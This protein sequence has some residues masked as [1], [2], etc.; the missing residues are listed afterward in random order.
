MENQLTGKL[1]AGWDKALPVFPADTKGAATRKSSGAVI[2]ALAGNLPALMGGS[3]DLAPSNNTLIKDSVDFQ[4]DTPEGRNMR[5]GVREHAMGAIINGMAYH[6][7]IIPYGATFM[8]FT[9][10][11]RPAMRLAALSHLPT[12]WVMTHDSIFLGEDGPTHQ[13]VEHLAAMRA[14][15]NLNVIRPADANE[16]TEAWKV[17]IESTSTPTMLALSRQNLPTLDRS[18]YAAADG[19]SK[20]AYVLKDFGSGTPDII[21][22][23]SGSEV[24]L[25]TTAGEA[26]AADG[27][28]VRLVSFPCWK[29]FSAQ[30][31]AYQESVLPKAVTK[32]L[33]V[34][35]GVSLG[36]ERW[37]GLDG[38]IIS[39]ERFGASAPAKILAEK[40]GF[41]ADNV[42]ARAKALLAA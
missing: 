29:L 4:A 3:A 24:S 39:I 1:P 32:R 34:E 2:N 7:G 19:L 31:A 20:G 41:T 33:A 13:P 11:V 28:N 36:W 8:V 9:D 27:I 12:I 42:I 23:A 26:L 21:L 17:A 40:F 14:I 6:K 37:I 38:D 15:P 10:Y 25:I 16:T 35:A 5:F 18:V 22:L 30:D